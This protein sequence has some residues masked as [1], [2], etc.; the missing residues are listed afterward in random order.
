MP[1]TMP[2]FHLNCINVLVDKSSSSS[3]QHDVQ[4]G[5]DN[6]GRELAAP[7]NT[8]RAKRLQW[9][10]FKDVL[11]YLTSNLARY[12][13]TPIDERDAMLGPVEEHIVTECSNQFSEAGH[14]AGDVRRVCN[15]IL[16][17]NVY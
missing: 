12:Q 11:V 1:S 5:Q 16:C 7:T 15:N 9:S 8:F 17:N 3:M 13:A 14:P 2:H 10:N 6:G 4:S